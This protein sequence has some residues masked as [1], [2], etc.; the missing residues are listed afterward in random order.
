[1]NPRMVR[2]REVGFTAAVI[3]ERTSTIKEIR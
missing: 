1:M 2:A 3:P